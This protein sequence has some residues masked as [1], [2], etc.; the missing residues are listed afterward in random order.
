MVWRLLDGP[1]REHPQMYD[2]A[3]ARD[4][5]LMILGLQLAGALTGAENAEFAR[6]TDWVVAQ[7]GGAH[8]ASWWG[9]IDANAMGDGPAVL[10]RL[11]DEFR[12]KA[13]NKL[14]AAE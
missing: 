6:F 11:L 7:F 4:V 1:L 5:H 3:N 2:I 14:A 13:Q 8:T 10:F 12:N 9:L